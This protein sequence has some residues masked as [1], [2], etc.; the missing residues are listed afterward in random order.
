MFRSN[1]S[2]IP[3][4]A[5][6]TVLSKLL[7]RTLTYIVEKKRKLGILPKYKYKEQLCY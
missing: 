3:R 4:T 2:H 1:Y 6:V 7:T 5:N